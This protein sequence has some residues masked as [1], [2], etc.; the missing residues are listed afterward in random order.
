MLFRSV[1]ELVK[2]KGGILT[3]HMRAAS[4]V[5][6]AYPLKPF[7]TP[8]NLIALKEVLDLALAT[9]VR[10]QIS[11]LI[12]VGSRSWKTIDKAMDMIDRA[13][14]QGADVGFDMF[15]YGCGASVI[16]GILPDWFMAE[17]PRAY[18]N[19][20]L[21]RKLNLMMKVSFKL[22]GF[23]TRDIYIAS[24][25]HPDLEQYNGLSLFEIAKKRKVS[26]FRNYIDF[27]QMSNSTA[28]VLMHKYRDRKSV[29]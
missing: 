24:A 3:V 17:L 23:D 14:K 11:H 29:V 26:Q 10:L 21:L 16:T 25:N 7:G 28:R 18:H 20:K 4:A 19:K 2:R 22:L 12:F 27:A 15:A 5:S 6:G 8:H 9:G 1:A 13:L